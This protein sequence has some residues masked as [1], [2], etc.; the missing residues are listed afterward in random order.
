MTRVMNVD[1]PHVFEEAQ[2]KPEWDAA[3]KEEYDSLVTY[4]NFA[5]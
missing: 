3:M 1:D 2:G 4:P 5:K